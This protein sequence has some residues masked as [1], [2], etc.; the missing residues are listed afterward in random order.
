LYEIV[1]GDK[2]LA[3]YRRPFTE[4]LRTEYVHTKINGDW[5]IINA[6]VSP[7]VCPAASS[8]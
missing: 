1:E 6:G 8:L 5:E 4:I 2:Y 3:D 7:P